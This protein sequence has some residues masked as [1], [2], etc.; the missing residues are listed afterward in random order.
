MAK[1][2]YL[3]VPMKRK[4]AAVVAM[5][6]CS[7]NTR[8]WEKKFVDMLIGIKFKTLRHWRLPVSIIVSVNI[9]S[10]TTKP[11]QVQD[12]FVWSASKPCERLN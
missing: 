11:P 12:I 6:F 2:G 5:L 4:Y 9:V 8:S 1:G 3:M 7:M 10:E